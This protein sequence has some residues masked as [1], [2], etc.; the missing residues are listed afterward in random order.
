MLYCIDIGYYDKLPIAKLTESLSARRT[1][2]R[3]TAGIEKSASVDNVKRYG[4][5]RLYRLYRRLLSA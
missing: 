5:K 3:E 1:F 4:D 2:Y